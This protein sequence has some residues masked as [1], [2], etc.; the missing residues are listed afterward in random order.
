MSHFTV[1]SL[2]RNPPP[3]PGSWRGAIDRG[4]HGCSAALPAPTPKL[5]L[6]SHF[7]SGRCWAR[8]LS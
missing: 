6:F 5:E 7:I 1:N 8:R 2:H 4:E 3:R